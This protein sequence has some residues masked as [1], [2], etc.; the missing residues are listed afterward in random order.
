MEKDTKKLLK[1]VSGMKDVELKEAILNLLTQEEEETPKVEE[2][3]V[4][5]PKETPKEEEKVIEPEV[6]EEPK[7][8]PK[9]KEDLEKE[10]LKKELETI[11]KE[12]EE[13]V[14]AN[15]TRLDEIQ[16]FLSQSQGFG[17]K[18]KPLPTEAKETVY[19]FD[20]TIARVTKRRG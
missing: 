11:K 18:A 16:N 5:E 19:D 2:P 6:K 10:A 3:K 13:L 1:V 20:N 14:L 7:E 8:E 4:E 9:P 15:K 12:K 17:L